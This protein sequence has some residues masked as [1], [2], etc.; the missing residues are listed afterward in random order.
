MYENIL[1]IISFKDLCILGLCAKWTSLLAEDLRVTLEP[2]ILVKAAGNTNLWRQKDTR[3]NVTWNLS[4]FPVQLYCLITNL[5]VLS[6]KLAFSPFQILTDLMHSAWKQ[7]LLS[8]KQI[9]NAK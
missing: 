7:V 2:F 5:G 4:Q 9:K 1:W 3:E 8:K 6:I